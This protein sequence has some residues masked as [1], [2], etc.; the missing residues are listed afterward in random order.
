MKA[1]NKSKNITIITNVRVAK[2]P[3]TRMVGLL[4]NSELPDNQGL[5]ITPCKS[6]HSWFMRFTFDAVFIDKE[7][8]VVHLIENMTPFNACMPVWNAS[9]VLEL[10][11]GTINNKGIS[12]S[13]TIL[14][15]D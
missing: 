9:K 15:E 5:L 7:G 11:A 6:I 2:N 12:I 3:I 10:P 14:F 4:L 13:D 1:I 8:K